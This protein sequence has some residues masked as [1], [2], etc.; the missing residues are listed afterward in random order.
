MTCPEFEYEVWKGIATSG[1]SDVHY[2]VWDNGSSF[3]ENGFGSAQTFRDIT[4][5]ATG[6]YF[7]DT[8]D[9]LA[10]HDDDGDGYA[11]NLTPEIKVSGGTWGTR[12]FI[13]LNTELFGTKGV[14]G[15]AAQFAAPGEPWRDA[16]QDG[17]RDAGEEWLNLTYPATLGGNF[18]I[19][20]SEVGKTYDGSGPIINTTAALWGILYNSGQFSP[21]GNATFYGSIIAKEGVGDSSPSAGT[22]Q[23]YWDESIK[24]SWPPD[25]WDLPR[26]MISRWETDL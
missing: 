24:E 20:D 16:D 15:R 25:G 12:G 26:V 7:F 2:Y 8:T 21:T 23:I 14:T 17:Q 9:S 10:P 22:P 11:D 18:V 5:Q 13:Y 19:D 3:K 6:L 4:D 1:A